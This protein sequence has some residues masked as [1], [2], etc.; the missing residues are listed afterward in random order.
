MRQLRQRQRDG[1]LALKVTV[2]EVALLW[3]LE[4]DDMAYLPAGREHTKAEIEEA[5][6]RFI[7]RTIDY[8]LRHSE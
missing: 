6:S 5:L 2:D 4:Q 3:A 1:L 7:A 8:V